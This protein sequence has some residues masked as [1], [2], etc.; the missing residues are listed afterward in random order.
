MKA[1]RRDSRRRL[2]VHGG[3][4]VSKQTVFQPG[5]RLNRSPTG[6]VRPA[7]AM[8][9]PPLDPSGKSDEHLAARERPHEQDISTRAVPSPLVDMHL[10]IPLTPVPLIGQVT[11]LPIES[12]TR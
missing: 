4:S 10:R 11:L 7:P 1:S 5:C 8:V 2:R 12:A 3:P 9:T 6:A